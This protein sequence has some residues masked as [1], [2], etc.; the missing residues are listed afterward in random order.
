[1]TCTPQIQIGVIGSGYFLGWMIGLAF[2][3][4]LADKFG[5][6][7]IYKLGMVLQFIPFVA[8]YF[9]TTLNHMIALYIVLGFTK[10]VTCTVWFVY[11]LEFIQPHIQVYCTVAYNF[12]DP[13]IFIMMTLYF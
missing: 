1:M 13:L 11:T 4:R 3:P 6:K 12:C 5:R 8:M 2:V 9:T 7:I 10:C